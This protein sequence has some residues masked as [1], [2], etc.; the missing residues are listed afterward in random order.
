M[1]NPIFNREQKLRKITIRFNHLT[2]T[3]GHA[4]GT[5]AI[6]IGVGKLKIN[7]KT[8]CKNLEKNDFIMVDEEG[9]YSVRRCAMRNIMVGTR[10]HTK[11]HIT[12]VAQGKIAQ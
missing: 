2:T 10:I 11:K 3:T 12:T 8:V 6:Y 4:I 7:N 9:S 1:F 5:M